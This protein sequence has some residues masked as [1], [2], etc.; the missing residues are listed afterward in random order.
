MKKTLENCRF[1]TMF[2]HFDFILL[3]GLQAGPNHEA[4]LQQQ[5]CSHVK[6]KTG[7]FLFDQRK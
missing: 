6:F 4:V 5:L 7:I 2:L 1:L 3:V